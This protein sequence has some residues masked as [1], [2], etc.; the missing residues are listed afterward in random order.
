MRFVSSGSVNVLGRFPMCSFIKI[1]CAERRWGR[2]NEGLT[3]EGKPSGG[4]LSS[5]GLVVEEGSSTSSSI[6]IE[7]LPSLSDSGGRDRVERTANSG[8]RAAG[9]ACSL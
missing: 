4:R 7:P 6:H 2:G 5:T 8:Q 1:P 3:K 9:P